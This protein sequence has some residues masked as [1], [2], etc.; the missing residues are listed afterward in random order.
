MARATVQPRGLRNGPEA[1]ADS[2]QAGSGSEGDGAS[3]ATMPGARV[4]WSI[5]LLS[6][7]EPLRGRRRRLRAN[8][9]V[10]SIPPVQAPEQLRGPATGHLGTECL[11]SLHTGPALAAV[12][13]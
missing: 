3:S 7:D 12:Q 11:K 13:G 9:E 4:G 6:L 8:Q 1:Y 2:L 10:S 5:R